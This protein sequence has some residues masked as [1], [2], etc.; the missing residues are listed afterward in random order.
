[1]KENTRTPFDTIVSEILQDADAPQMLQESLDAARAADPDRAEKI[2]LR[3]R[4]IAMG[5]LRKTSPEDLSEL[6][7]K[8]GC[9][10]LY[11]RSLW[12]AS[13][14]YAF[15]HGLSYSRW[16]RLRDICEEFRKEQE[17]EDRYFQNASV[18]LP[19]LKSYIEENSADCA[20]SYA[21]AKLTRF[22]EDRLAE[23]PEDEDAFRQFLVNNATAFSPV[24]EKTRYYFCK[25]LYY[26]L[27]T[28]I[29]R[30][31]EQLERGADAEDAFADLVVF[32]G[33][34]PLKRKKHS[35]DE[36][37]AFLSETDISCGEVF[38]AFNYYFFDYV[39]ADWMQ[40]LLDYY[41]NINA[42]PA[43]AKKALAE[44][45]RAYD[46]KLYGGLD[47]AA[48][49]KLCGEKLEAD[50]NALDEI[51]S[52]SG[53]SRGYQR[54]RVGENAIRKYIKGSL[55]IDRT[56]LICFL[57]FFG[58][59]AELSEDDAITKERLTDILLECGFAGL[60]ED[61]PFDDFVTRYLQAEDPVDCL[62]QEATN[63]ALEEK[64]FYLYRVYQRSSRLAKPFEE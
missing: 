35:A 6:L 5:F 55:D 63:F 51:Y 58:S 36:A 40:I 14:I 32:K 64:N 45:L 27:R 59:E 41:G 28:R 16:Q 34:S 37:R 57:L 13:L 22:V 44:H 52:L 12:E 39:S 38:D 8:H 61:D 9:P 31:L 21:T 7:K 2:P 54:N 49:L 56:T 26:M 23:T 46:P 42:L 3:Y 29:D 60:R 4:L 47:T 50:E 25:Y 18:S 10:A 62:M 53:D 17:I 19:E 1:M 43:S 15:L 33:L 20:T 11:A 30:Y 24:R 48:V